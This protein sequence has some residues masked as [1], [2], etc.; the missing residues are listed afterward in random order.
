MR[1][2]GDRRAVGARPSTVQRAAVVV[3][4]LLLPLAAI[5]LVGAALLRADGWSGAALVLLGALLLTVG[6]A[7]LSRPAHAEHLAARLRRSPR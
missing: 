2:D 6:I 3:G 4:W 1:G 7:A 5:V